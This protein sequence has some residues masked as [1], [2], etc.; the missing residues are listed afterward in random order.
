VTTFPS[1][2]GHVDNAA[3]TGFERCSIVVYLASPKY[4]VDIPL[5][6][7]ARTID[8]VSVNPETPTSEV[9]DAVIVAYVIL[10]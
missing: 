1:D 7:G 8:S 2:K 5:G 9:F 6:L 4:A 10:H 3:E